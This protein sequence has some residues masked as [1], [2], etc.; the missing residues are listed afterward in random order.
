MGK[1]RIVT[2]KGQKVDK[3]L[4]ARSLARITKKKIVTATA[5]VQSTFN[6]TIVTLTEMDGAV[7]ASTTS[8]SLG[9]KGA[10][11]GT[12]YAAAEVG[13]VIAERAEQIGVKEL[14]IVVRG[15]GSGREAAIRS[16]ASHGFDVLSIQD[17]TPVPHNGPRPKKA[18]RV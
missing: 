14:H 12:P 11:K 4:K 15:I 9:F 2:S 13:K 10:K 5:H 8:G 1:K 7:V 17:K 6:N 16:L 18:R 3:S